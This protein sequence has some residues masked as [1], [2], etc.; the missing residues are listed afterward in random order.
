MQGLEYEWVKGVRYQNRIESFLNEIDA[1]MVPTLS[2]R[3]CICLL[4]TSDAAD[5]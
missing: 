3:V 5:D 4:Y 1:I 2:E